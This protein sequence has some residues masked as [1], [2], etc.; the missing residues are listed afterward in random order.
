MKEIAMPVRSRNF[1]CEEVAHGCDAQLAE[2]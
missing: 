2:T 1:A